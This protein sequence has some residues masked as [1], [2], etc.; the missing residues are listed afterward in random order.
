MDWR[1]IA[2]LVI[3]LAVWFL[4]LPVSCVGLGQRPEQLLA[5]NSGME[6]RL[7]ETRIRDP[8]RRGIVLR[9]TLAYSNS[10]AI[11]TDKSE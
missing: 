8:V 7:P 1:N 9:C 4:L 2:F 11:F 3:F 6:A 5:G 10:F